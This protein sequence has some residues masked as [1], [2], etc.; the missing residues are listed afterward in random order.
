M[1]ER[2]AQV[3]VWQMCLLPHFMGVILRLPRKAC[4]SFVWHQIILF[5]FV[6]DPG[7]LFF[8]PFVGFQ[9][10]FKLSL[11]F[12]GTGSGLGSCS[13]P[14]QRPCSLFSVFAGT[15]RDLPS[16]GRASC[17]H[18]TQLLPLQWKPASHWPIARG[19]RFV[20]IFFSCKI[21]NLS[22]SPSCTK[23]LGFCLF[24]GQK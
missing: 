14:H 20:Y 10:K 13:L 6:L 9:G 7:S 8:F 11:V 3:C 12:F 17:P 1:S 4:G 21:R 23:I 5:E 24:S 18:A 16:L 19:E 15:T 22:Q 2:R